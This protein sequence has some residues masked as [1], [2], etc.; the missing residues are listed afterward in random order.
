[1][2][3]FNFTDIETYKLKINFEIENIKRLLCFR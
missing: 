2:E 1:M 3:C